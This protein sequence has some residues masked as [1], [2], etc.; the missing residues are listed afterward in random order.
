MIQKL[1]SESSLSHSPSSTSLFVED[2]SACFEKNVDDGS[3]SLFNHFP[4]L[5]PLQFP[6]ILPQKLFS[7]SRVKRQLLTLTFAPNLFLQHQSDLFSFRLFIIFCFNYFVFYLFYSYCS[8]PCD[9][10]ST[11]SR[12]T[13][14]TASPLLH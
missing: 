6:L 11:I 5:F 1:L 4:C 2:F 14:R 8:I 9:D 10:M 13:Y 3:Q 12:K 7:A